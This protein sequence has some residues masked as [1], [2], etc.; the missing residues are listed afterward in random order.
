VLTLSP[1][2]RIYVALGPTNLRQSFN[3]LS[4]A[5]AQIIGE[6]PTSG[7]LFF[8]CNRRRTQ[9]RILWWDGTGYCI[10]AKRL[11]RG[12]FEV[13]PAREDATHVEIDAETLQMLLGGIDLGSARRRRRFRLVAT[14]A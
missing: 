5:A 14:G 8:F 2:V 7:H 4:L 9:L 3:G 10:Y 12:T 1:A 13:P 6:E 11:A